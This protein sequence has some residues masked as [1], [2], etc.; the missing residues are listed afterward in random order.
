MRI[1]DSVAQFEQ[2][3]QMYLGHGLDGSVEWVNIEKYE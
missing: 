1:S 3:A 2:N